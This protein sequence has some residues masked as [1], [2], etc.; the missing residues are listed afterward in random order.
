MF[1]AAVHVRGD[2]ELPARN[3]FLQRAVVL[4]AEGELATKHHL[5]QNSAGPHIHRLAKLVVL[6]YYF[7]GHLARSSAEDIQLFVARHGN[8]KAE[9][10]NL[11]I[12]LFIQ[13]NILKL[14]VAMHNILGVHVLDGLYD[15]LKYASSFVLG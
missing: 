5:E 3:L 4:A 7:G 1:G 2:I 6:G 10:N 8:R 14:D 12:P 13:D 11:D 15:L 9:V